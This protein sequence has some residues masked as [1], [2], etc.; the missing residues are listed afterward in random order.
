[1]DIKYRRLAASDSIPEI[2][3]LLHRAYGALAAR[4]MKFLASH[5]GDDITRE[6]LFGGEAW[7]AVEG[8]RV[9]GTVTVRR[10]CSDHAWYERP[11]VA[12][13]EQL[14]VEPELQ[15]HGVGGRLISIAEDVGREWGRTEMALDT[16]ERAEDLIALYTKRG[17]R[18]VGEVR[19]SIVNYGSVVLSKA[20]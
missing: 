1:M 13:M 6:R 17:Y 18:V 7:V 15:R 9:V 14:A 19:R 3:A 4:G 2:T 16:S 8:A 10:R 5:Q 12:S 20:L 11:E